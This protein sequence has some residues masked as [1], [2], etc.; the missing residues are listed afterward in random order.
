MKTTHYFKAGILVLVLAASVAFKGEKDKLHKRDFTIQLTEAKK[1]KA[2]QDEVSFKDGKVYCG[3]VLNEKNSDLS[4]MKYEI[5]VDS[6]YN[7][8]GE[9]K[10]YIEVLATK[11]LE[12]GEM[13]EMKCVVD[14][15][16]IE[17]SMRIHKAGKDKKNWT[18]T[19][20]EVP[21]K[22]KKK[23]DEESK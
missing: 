19:G 14:N 9:D 10:E 7:D 18:F 15:H 3:D 20:K 16:E 8:E 23:K 6:T 21:K 2:L 22:E 13:F 5:K 1:P 12:R 4:W 11:E 17:G